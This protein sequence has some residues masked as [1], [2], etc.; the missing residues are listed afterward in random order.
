MTGVQTCA[1]PIFDGDAGEVE[2]GWGEIDPR[3][4]GRGDDIALG[5]MGGAKKNP[6]GQ[7]VL[8][9]AKETRVAIQRA[10]ILKE[11]VEE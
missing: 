10:F 4:Q 1:L 6:L 9:G 3:Y 5:L 11:T 2:N 8:H 7:F